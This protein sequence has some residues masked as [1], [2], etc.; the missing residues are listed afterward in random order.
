MARK[1]IFRRGRR[2][3]NLAEVVRRLEKGEWIYW[4]H[5]PQH[6]GWLWSMRIWNL[7]QA[8]FSGILYRAI[9]NEEN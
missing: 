1:K 3:K 7:R 6:P 5:K 4:N 9:R 2:I 8:A